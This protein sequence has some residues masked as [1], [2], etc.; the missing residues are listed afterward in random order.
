MSKT[1]T[2]TMALLMYADREVYATR[3]FTRGL[4]AVYDVPLFSIS[5]S[6]C[7]YITHSIR[8][9][10][11]LTVLDQMSLRTTSEELDRTS[12]GHI[13]YIIPRIALKLSSQHCHTRSKRH[14][15]SAEPLYWKSCE[16]YVYNVE[17]VA[18]TRL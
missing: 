16:C 9:S 18:H 10:P 17:V 14:L 13:E 1:A 5:Q 7:T 15:K 12:T 11:T 3:N 4:R 6:T 8:S 2:N